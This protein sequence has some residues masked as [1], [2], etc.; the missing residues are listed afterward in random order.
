[1]RVTSTTYPNLV[2]NSS[3]NAQQ[4]LAVL[5]QQIGTGTSIQFASDN[6]LAYAQAA[7]TQATLSQLN[8]YNSS[9]TQATTLTTQNNQAMTSLHQIVAQASESATTITSNMTPAE[10]QD[11]GTQISSLLTQLTSIVNQTSTNG[12]YLFG[13]TANQPPIN[14]STQ[15]YNAST[16]GQTN[17]IE[18]QQG[19]SVQTG[20]AA[21]RSGTPPVDGFLYDSAS[22]VDV[23]ATLKQTV[24]DLN[25]GNASAVQTTDV[26][27]LNKA[28]DHISL[29]VGSTAASMSAVDTASQ[30]NQQQITSSNNQLNGLIQTN[31]PNATVQLQQIQMQYQASLSAGSRILGLSLMNYLP[32]A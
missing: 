4:Q 22:G 29:Y 13:G 21:G 17:S 15:T 12:S 7:Q 28:L 9:I 25:A 2:I 1:M 30:M 14:A 6:P 16:N 10:M 31:L 18:V 32:T 23:L 8:A 24:T 27:A 3:Q 5:Q 20:I 11:V 26:T 19:N